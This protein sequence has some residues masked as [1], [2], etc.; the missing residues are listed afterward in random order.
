MPALP[1]FRDP[2]FFAAALGLTVVF[3]GLQL[4]Q[5]PATTWDELFAPTS[6]ILLEAGLPLRSDLLLLKDFCGG[7][8]VSTLSA[9]AL[10]AFLPADVWAWRLVPFGFGL[11]I[12]AGAWRLGGHLSGR[13]GAATA[14]WLYVLG[15]PAYRHMA[16][17]GY[18]NHVEVMALVFGALLAAVALDARGRRRDSLVLGL[19]CG[20]S[21]F[22]AYIA[23]FV[24]PAVAV[25][26]WVRRGPRPPVRVVPLLAG[27]AIGFSPWVLVRALP[28]IRSFT[29]D[30]HGRTLGAILGVDVS[31]GE[32][33]GVLFG[34]LF[35]GNLFAPAFDTWPR[36]GLLWAVPAAL[37][38]LAVG[39]A[40]RSSTAAAG[41]AAGIG[42]FVV[43]WL[44]LAPGMPSWPPVS[45][46]GGDSIHYLVPLLTLVPVAAAAL[47]R[48]G[49]LRP[50][51]G[52]VI[53]SLALMGLVGLGADWT[54]RWELDELTRP[55][56]D[57]RPGAIQVTTDPPGSL[58]DLLSDD[59][60]AVLGV[61][62]G[63]LVARRA[64]L[65][66]LGRLL[67][68]LLG[69]ASPADRRALVE[70]VDSLPPGDERW[71]FW[72]IAHETLPREPLPGPLPAGLSALLAEWPAPMR[73]RF[74]R[75][76]RHDI[77]EE[78]VVNHPE[79]AVGR[80]AD[81]L[82]H[83][84]GTTDPALRRQIAWELGLTAALAAELGEPVE[85]SAVGQ[86]RRAMEALP[87]LPVGLQT[88]ALEGLVDTVVW[89]RCQSGADCA[90]LRDAV[91]AEGI[92]GFDVSACAHHMR[93]RAPGE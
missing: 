47:W 52:P 83:L 79:R 41:V 13:A 77:A 46:G 24:L 70:F 2:F 90:A 71:L 73:E 26:L 62:P 18:A 27:A 49:P 17:R 20:A 30:V 89:D 61:R 35:W 76:A 50:L 19:L 59:V 21:L 78:R 15:P 10:F 88:P 60:D 74:L 23:A 22:Y 1:S 67:P 54:G 69:R 66:S 36:I 75:Q 80:T 3:W 91:P 40:A 42:F 82:G 86:L 8:A 34:P 6:A 33:L 55:A 72:G 12:L 11:A 56:T 16:V 28:P 25:G 81:L 37:A 65:G 51:A 68:G 64:V 9:R 87:E 29:P 93:C 44:L 63:R 92:P 7:C 31:V 48:D 14:A 5:G 32:R 57:A 84:A 45:R 4:A 43:E 53:A 58:Q 38:A 85:R 39:S